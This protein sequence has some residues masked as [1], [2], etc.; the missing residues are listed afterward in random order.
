MLACELHFAGTCCLHFKD[1][2]SSETSENSIIVWGITFPQTVSFTVTAIR[3]SYP[4][5]KI[6]SPREP[7]P[8]WI[9]IIQEDW[10]N[11]IVFSDLNYFVWLKYLKMCVRRRSYRTQNEGPPMAY[12]RTTSCAVHYFVSAGCAH[13]WIMPS[14]RLQD[15]VACL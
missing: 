13:V 5:N 3:T 15:F 1:S 14:H 7:T 2:I 12:R 4:T 11:E 8:S 10:K 6:V 9:L